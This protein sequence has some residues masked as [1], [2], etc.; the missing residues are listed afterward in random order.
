MKTGPLGLAQTSCCCRAELI[1][2]WLGSG[3][4]KNGS[5]VKHRIW[6]SRVEGSEEVCFAEDYFKC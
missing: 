3:I 6:F 2:I 1:W 5:G 4:E